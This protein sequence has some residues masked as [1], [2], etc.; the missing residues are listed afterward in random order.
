MNGGSFVYRRR[1]VSA[2]S[3]QVTYTSPWVEYVFVS[4]YPGG[5]FPWKT[6]VLV[7]AVAALTAVGSESLKRPLEL[8]GGTSCARLNIVP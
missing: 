8:G 2:A 4:A 5:T 1:P 7:A 6:E 3:P